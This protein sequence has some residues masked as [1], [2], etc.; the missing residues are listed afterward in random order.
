M[1]QKI[2]EKDLCCSYSKIRLSFSDK[3]QNEEKQRLMLATKALQAQNQISFEGSVPV[4]FFVWKL[5]DYT[6]IT[7]RKNP[8]FLQEIQEKEDI[9]TKMRLQTNLENLYKCLI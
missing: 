3:A 6:T 4:A 8:Q 2:A 7:A 9:R 5:I 1:T